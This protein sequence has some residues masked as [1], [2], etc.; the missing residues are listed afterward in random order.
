MV[1]HEFTHLADLNPKIDV[2]P[3]YRYYTQTDPL[4]N[5]PLDAVYME[6]GQ[7]GVDFKKSG[8][9]RTGGRV[10]AEQGRDGANHELTLHG[11]DGSSHRLR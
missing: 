11:A 4:F 2:G 8:S 3:D 1:A 5:L 6:S 10:V 7:V 9:G